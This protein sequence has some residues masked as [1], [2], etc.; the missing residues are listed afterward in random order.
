MKKIFSILA[1]ALVAFGFTACQPNPDEPKK[2]AIRVEMSEGLLLTDMT[3]DS[4]EGWWQVMG[5]SEE[6]FVTLS[7]AGKVSQ[8]AGT[9]A[10]ADLDPDYSFIA[11]AKD[12][13]KFAD[14]SIKASKIAE[15][16]YTFVGNVDGKDGKAYYINLHYT[17][18]QAKKTVELNC[19][20]AKL[21]DESYAFYGIFT[22]VGA[23]ADQTSGISLYVDMRDQMA[24]TYTTEDIMV[25]YSYV[26]ADEAYQ[27]IYSANFTIVEAEDHYDINGEFLCYNNTLYK[28]SLKPAKD[29]IIPPT[30][31]EVDLDLIATF[32]DDYRDMDGSYVIYFDDDLSNPTVE[33]ALNLFDEDF[34]GTFGINDI[35]PEYSYYA[36]MVDGK[37]G[38]QDLAVTA[39]LSGDAKSSTY[40]GYVIANNGI[41]YKFDVVADLED[42]LSEADG[43]PARMRAKNAK[44]EFKALPLKGAKKLF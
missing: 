17:A 38:I 39:T 26:Y 40:T 16:E 34:A 21:D 25:N 30:G 20:N 23:T 29:V 19:A 33:I 31:E 3:A 32:I 6:Y 44:L 5:E 18:P 9:Y 28:V 37:L 42:L 14:G 43:A 41:K 35:D 13:I 22:L 1:V 2:D 24:G 36:D 12:T 15:D 27:Q 7:N 8:I 10:V 11:T 4:T